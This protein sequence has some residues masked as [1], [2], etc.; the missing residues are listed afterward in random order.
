[1]G[2]KNNPGT[3]DCYANAEPDEPMF[4]LL[5][6]DPFAPALVEYWANIRES[7]RGPS[8][9]VEEARACAASMRRWRE[10]ESVATAP[11]HG[12]RFMSAHGEDAPGRSRDTYEQCFRCGLVRHDYSHNGGQR[13]P[14]Y[15]IY[16][17]AGVH[18]A[19]EPPCVPSPT[20]SDPKEN[21]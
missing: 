13:S 17:V 7:V 5:G 6:R 15:P 3:Y 4:I 20:S 1:M 10:K 14:N 9:K 18:H 12:W 2:T 19:A 8:A 11:A 21:G 16:L